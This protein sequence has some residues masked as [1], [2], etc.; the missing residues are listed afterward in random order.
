MWTRDGTLWGLGFVPAE[1]TTPPHSVATRG[2][3][4][5]GC[6]QKSASAGGSATVIAGTGP[7]GPDKVNVR[8]WRDDPGTGTTMGSKV[9]VAP[10]VASVYCVAT[11]GGAGMDFLPIFKAK[12]KT[13][14]RE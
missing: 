9:L 5:I 13:T 1:N 8:S 7:P 3:S 12:L 10:S 6:A 2:R 4:T 11:P 14:F